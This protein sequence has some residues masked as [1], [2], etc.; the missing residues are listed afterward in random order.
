MDV[1]PNEVI[2]YLANEVTR[3]SIDNA[4]LRA[5]L[6]AKEKAEEDGK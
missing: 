3:L 1:N 6:E 5:A 2:K 4:V